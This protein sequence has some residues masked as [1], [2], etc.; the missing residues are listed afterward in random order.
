MPRGVKPTG[1]PRGRPKNPDNEGGRWAVY[2]STKYKPALESLAMKGHRT[3]RSEIELA[4]ERHIER[5]Q[6][7]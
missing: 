2:L 6:K 7:S 3:V 4:I 1:K 5:E